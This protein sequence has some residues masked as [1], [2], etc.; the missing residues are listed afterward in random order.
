MLQ[1]SFPS[2]IPQMNQSVRKRALA[3]AHIFR[4]Y[5]PFLGTRGETAYHNG[6]PWLE[7][8]VHLLVSGK[9][10]KETS[11]TQSPSR[12]H[13]PYLLKVLPPFNST[14]LRTMGNSLNSNYSHSSDRTLRFPLYRQQCF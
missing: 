7:D 12:T 9:L 6:V 3:L 8:S 1:L 13:S 11:A 14:E 2:Q 10:K 4:G 5:H